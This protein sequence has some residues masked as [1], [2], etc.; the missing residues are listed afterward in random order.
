MSNLQ[1]K[2]Y[3]QIAFSIQIPNLLRLRY[4]INKYVIPIDAVD[5][6]LHIPAVDIQLPDINNDFKIERKYESTNYETG[7]FG[8]GWT[9]NIECYLEEDD[10]TVTVLCSDGHIEIFNFKNEKY[11]NT[12]FI[13]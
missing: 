13:L 3:Q 2:F 12:K 1:I 11:V 5:G 9:S 8:Y 4:F 10:D 6:S 7:I